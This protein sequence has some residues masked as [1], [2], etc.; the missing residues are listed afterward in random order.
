MFS[1]FKNTLFESIEYNR[2]KSVLLLLSLLTFISIGVPV[3]SAEIQTKSYP[4][5]FHVDLS[6]Y[7]PTS[8]YIKCDVKDY[9]MPFP[10]F[11][12]EEKGPRESRF[13]EFVVAM[14][15]ND[16]EKCLSISFM[17]SGMN[18]AATR[19]HNDRV[20]TMVSTYRSWFLSN[21][22]AGK[23]LEKLKVFSQF[24]LGS[25]GL[26]VFGGE[27]K[28]PSEL[29]PFRAR[30]KFV[31]TPRGKFSLTV[32]NPST[33]DSLLGEAM[34]RM[35]VSPSKFV[36]MENKKFEY[37]VPIPDTNDTVHVAYLQFNGE[38]YD[39]SVFSDK[40]NYIEKDTDEVVSF[41]QEKYL[42]IKAGVPREDLA[43]LYTSESSQEYLE[44]AEDPGPEE[45]RFEDWAT[46]KKTVS[47][48]IDAKP[49]YIVLYQR[50]NSKQIYYQ[51]IVRDPKDEKLKLANFHCIGYL[52][53]LMNRQFRSLLSEHIGTE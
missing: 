32:E 46:V 52:D 48:V 30:L 45:W 8:L 24:Y 29:H 25:N 10:D 23:N 2:G 6:Y 28:S 43:G 1:N 26:F 31:N 17:E 16:I 19:K 21:D 7:I 9:N 20:E 39:F 47:F 35:A 50:G 12:T 51:Y 11:A 41:F 34:R 38:K 14:R 27:R 18:E 53:D 22:L 4:L 40:L 36:A 37:E 44:W 49:L 15:N 13:T 42:M 3:M 5:A 33:L